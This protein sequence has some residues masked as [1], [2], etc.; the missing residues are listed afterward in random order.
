MTNERKL[1]IICWV[2]AWALI[3]AVHVIMYWI[4]ST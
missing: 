2:A 1:D 4:L 3:A